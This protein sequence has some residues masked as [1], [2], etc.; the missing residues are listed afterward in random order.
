MRSA[1]R[2]T[3]LSHAALIVLLAILPFARAIRGPFIWDDRYLLSQIQNQDLSGIL[4]GSFIERPGESRG[5][6]YRPLVSLSL[7]ADTAI[8]GETPMGFH[9][10]NMGIYALCALAAW[11]LAL[12]WLSAGPAFTAAAIFAVY[13]VHCEPVCWISGRTDL[14][15]GLFILLTVLTYLRLR[16]SGKEYVALLFA[17]MALLAKESAAA[18]VLLVPISLWMEGERKFKSLALPGVA[19][20]VVA[21]TYFGIRALTLPVT[22]PHPPGSLPGQLSVAAYSLLM[23]FQML[24]LPSTA[25][26]GYPVVTEEVANLSTWFFVAG[27]LSIAIFAWQERRAH[28]VPWFSTAW[29]GACLLPVLGSAVGLSG[30]VV[31]QR[32]VFTASIAAAI[33]LAWALSRLPVTLAR[34][35]AA[36]LIA[37]LM[38]L[39]FS[40][41]GLWAD[42]LVFWR[43]MVADAPTMGW[44]YYNLGNVAV[45]RQNLPLALN[46]YKAAAALMP[47][48]RLPQNALEEVRELLAAQTRSQPRR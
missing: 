2:A 7:A 28:P 21:G 46:S 26:L 48:E 17:L 34:P 22:P 23:H 42:D 27:L 40:R 24:A 9:L 4:R 37:A 31:A 14:L 19:L 5:D 36:G 25:R 38:A 10:T 11:L 18:I 32:Y 12:R 39:S 15:A 1:S 3:L 30:T 16:G 13:P 20:A 41:A 44:G 33:L 8:W 43:Q 29:F 6:Y 35:F 45:E 47:D